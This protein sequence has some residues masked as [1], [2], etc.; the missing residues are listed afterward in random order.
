MVFFRAHK[1]HEHFETLVHG[2]FNGFIVSSMEYLLLL[3]APITA[4][5]LSHTWAHFVSRLVSL[6]VGFIAGYAH[7]CLPH[8][9]D[10]SLHNIFGTVKASWVEVDFQPSSNLISLY[11]VTKDS[12]ASNNRAISYSSCGTQRTKNPSNRN[13]ITP[14]VSYYWDFF[15]VMNCRIKERLL[16]KAF[17]SHAWCFLSNI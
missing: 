13:V 2:F 5:L 14:Y 1:C 15:F 4:V 11:H 3:V 12:S 10:K 16:W 9:P 17:T 6:F 8:L 7:W